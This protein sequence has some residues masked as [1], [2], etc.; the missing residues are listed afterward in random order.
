MTKTK[1]IGVMLMLA[2]WT[3]HAQP[4]IVT[5]N[6]FVVQAPANASS[7]KAGMVDFAP[8]LARVTDDLKQTFAESPADRTNFAANLQAINALIAEHLKDGNREQLA[9]LYLLDAHIYADGL[10]NNFK[11]RAIWV[12]VAR[13]FPGTVAAR[14]AAISLANLD[15]RNAAA[16]ELDVPEGLNI[17]Q[18]FPG[19]AEQDLAGNPLSVSAYRGKV[20][21]VDFWATWCGPCRGELPNVIATYQKYHNLGF[22]IIGVSLDQNRDT[23][24]GFINASGMAWP[25]YFDGQGWQNKLAQQYQVRSIPMDYLLDRHGIIIG[26]ELRGSA[27]GAAV[28]SALAN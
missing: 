4:V 11:A 25:Q 22:E 2:A 12:Q 23:L 21:M 13:D 3:A 9:R 26:K 10:T 17:G 20:T 24:T 19:F 18:K 7:G 14:G 28:E 16:G 8:E 6:L 27:L 1:W 5:P 15:A